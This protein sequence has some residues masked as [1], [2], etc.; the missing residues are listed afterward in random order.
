MCAR[1]AVRIVERNRAAQPSAWASVGG[2]QQQQQQQ[3]GGASGEVGNVAAAL[4]QAASARAQQQDA[5]VL[6][7]AYANMA[8][9]SLADND[10]SAA[11]VAARA[12][13][14]LQGLPELYAFL[15]NVYAAEAYCALNKPALALQHLSPAALSDSPVPNTLAFPSPYADLPAPPATAS[16][17]MKAALY[18]NMAVAHIVG[19]DDLAQA[20]QCVQQSLALHPTAHALL[21]Q[22][23]V[24]LRHGNVEAAVELLRRGRL[25]AGRRA[26]AKKRPNDA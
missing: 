19:K 25:P 7:A 26:S 20:Q 12:L 4:L 13:L 14:A 15:G 23:Y 21:L 1:N 17:A 6:R 8:F 10:P 2:Q 11:L 16:A 5:D 3:P 18:A 9:L 24:E 22:V